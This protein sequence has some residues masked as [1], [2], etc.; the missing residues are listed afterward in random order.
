MQV[1]AK[2]SAGCAEARRYILTMAGWKA[3]LVLM[4]LAFLTSSADIGA[5]RLAADEPL[6]NRVRSGRKQP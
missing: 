1:S 5:G 6:A 4:V 2:P 3:Y